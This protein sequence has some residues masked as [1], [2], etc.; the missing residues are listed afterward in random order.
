MA[1]LFVLMLDRFLECW[2]DGDGKFRLEGR[3]LQG[4][5]E[6]QGT[7]IRRLVSFRKAAEVIRTRP[8]PYPIAVSSRRNMELV[9]RVGE[10]S[11]CLV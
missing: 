11:Q 2:P 6:R 3:P 4:F 1:E 10:I 5:D 8:R 9:P 7:L